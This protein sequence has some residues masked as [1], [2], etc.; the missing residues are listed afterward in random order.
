M[1]IHTTFDALRSAYPQLPTA[2]IQRLGHEAGGIKPLV[3]DGKIGPKTRGGIYLSPPVVAEAGCTPATVALAELLAGAQETTRNAGPWVMKYARLPLGGDLGRDRGAWCAF[4]ASWCLDVWA[5]LHGKSFPAEG[6]ARAVVR[7]LP[8]R[9]SLADGA[10]ALQVG[11]L[12][13]WPSLTRASWAGHVGICVAKD[14]E[15][16]YFIEG[17]IDLVG[18]LDGVSCR[19]F[20]RDLVRADGARPLYAG[21]LVL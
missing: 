19:Y 17:N 8:L 15:G 20:K 10:A 12:V 13:A 18:A 11:D 21:R 4:F 7:G 5:R 1:T 9:V 16:F 14:D 2:V 6:G 3:C